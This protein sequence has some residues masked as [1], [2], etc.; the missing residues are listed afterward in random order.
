MDLNQG[1]VQQ[2]KTGFVKYQSTQHTDNERNEG[3]TYPNTKRPETQKIPQG[4]TQPDRAVKG[5]D[6]LRCAINGR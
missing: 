4:K 3:Q 6:A 2:P 5:N 1:H